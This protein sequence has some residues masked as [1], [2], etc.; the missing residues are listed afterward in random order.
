M[1]YKVLKTFT[2]DRR[3]AIGYCFPFY[4]LML[5]F[6]LKLNDDFQKLRAMC[7]HSGNELRS[8]VPKYSRQW[9]VSLL[10]NLMCPQSIISHFNLFT[11]I[12]Q[13]IGDVC[14]KHHHQCC[15][16]DSRAASSAP[17]TAV[18]RLLSSAPQWWMPGNVSCVTRD[19]RAL[20]RSLKRPMFHKTTT[21]V[22]REPTWAKHEI[23]HK[24]TAL[25]YTDID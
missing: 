17:V 21:S 10:Y 5:H 13:L 12:T 25:C 23:K 16:I 19:H 24:H 6:T 8:Q 22:L 20:V 3:L 4:S 11:R 15:V 1:I 9:L 18:S 2:G 14:L 7:F